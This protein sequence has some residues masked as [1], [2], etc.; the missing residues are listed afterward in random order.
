MTLELD[1]GPHS[2]SVQAVDAS[3]QVSGYTETWTVVVELPALLALVRLVI[4]DQTTGEVTTLELKP[5][6]KYTLDV[7][8]E[9]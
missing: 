7:I 6:H 8:T 2:W 4:R 3:D 1:E 9:A 5:L